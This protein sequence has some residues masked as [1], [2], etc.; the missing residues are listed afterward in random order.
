[1]AAKRITVDEWLAELNRVSKDQPQG[2]SRKDVQRTLAVCERR[3]LAIM[4]DW[5]D[6]GMIYLSGK[7]DG[8]S[9]DGK[10]YAVP[11]YLPVKNKAKAPRIS[12][13]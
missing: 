5:M 3:A 4:H 2:F 1:M 9:M 12:R 10:R 8:Y 7:R 11:V 6:R 13:R